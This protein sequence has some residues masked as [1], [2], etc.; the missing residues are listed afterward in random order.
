MG[1]TYTKIK[2]RFKL[3][4]V[5]FVRS[6]LPSVNTRKT[7]DV[8]AFSS[9]EENGIV[10]VKFGGLRAVTARDCMFSILCKI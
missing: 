7:K 5:E 4:I 3:V 6:R 8:L 10:A 1:N 9:S 2:D